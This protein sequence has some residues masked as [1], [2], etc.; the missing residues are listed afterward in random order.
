MEDNITAL[1]RDVVSVQ[2]DGKPPVPMAPYGGYGMPESFGGMPSTTAFAPNL[3]PAPSPQPGFMSDIDASADRAQQA[4]VGPAR[5]AAERQSWADQQF[6]DNSTADIRRQ[7][8][9]WSRERARADDPALRPWN[10]DQERAARTRGPMEQ[11]GSIGMIF[12]MAASAFTRTPMTSALNAGAAA[13]TA[14]QKGDEKAYESAYKA[15]KDNS[16]LALKR[17]DMEHRL[18]ED[19]NQ[20]LTTDVNLW[21]TK[22][23]QIAA[24]FDDQKKIVM[25]QNG[26]DPEVLKM[27]E[28]LARS[29]MELVKAKE[30]MEEVYW[31]GK[32][33]SEGIKALRQA[34]PDWKDDNKSPEQ[35]AA[36]AQ[37]YARAVRSVKGQVSETPEERFDR[38]LALELQREVARAAEGDKSRTA[39]QER[40]ETQQAGIAARQ[41][42]RPQ[43]M[44]ASDA[45]EVA[46]RTEKFETDPDSPTYG[47]H[48][49][50][51]DRA[52][53][54]V[55]AA[56]RS[57]KDEVKPT[58][59][60]EAAQKLAERLVA[61][62]KSGLQGLGYGAPG[63]ANRA[64]VTNIAAKLAEERGIT[65]EDWARHNIEFQ[66]QARGA[67]NLGQLESRMVAA[68]S[69]AQQTAPRVLETSSAVDRTKYPTLNSAIL[70]A[71]KGTGDEKVL[72]FGIAVETF[73]ANYAAALGQGAT[74]M[75]DNARQRASKL[76]ETSYS[77]GQVA[78]AIDQLR[79]EMQSELR[80][81][82]GSMDK[83]LDKNPEPKSIES[84]GSEPEGF[85]ATKDGWMWEK[86]KGRMVPLY[87][88]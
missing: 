84:K 42:N 3:S 31:R 15:W 54:Q 82:R 65:G 17:F 1:N 8:D 36:E 14:I 2:V 6:Q 55:L 45:A 38:M 60:E 46:K 61:G 70:A 4:L 24:Q 73:I 44:S 67:S 56:H 53:E 11:F 33:I 41:E 32:M 85:R 88:L 83:Y 5:Q 49:K 75:T 66:A 81:V 39:A 48:D 21:K 59:T 47:D 23:L 34:N 57:K 68:I 76:L 72:R 69:K 16:D 74:V 7:E 80:G 18:Y 30:G 20:L 63:A 52:A 12:A 77:K 43:S 25:L 19:A 51:R 22:T 28:S 86:R 29:R 87:E 58:L 13:M 26:M 71:E 27:S 78:S 79:V 40:V 9:A 10:A 50:S 64:L 62:D 35:A 37:V